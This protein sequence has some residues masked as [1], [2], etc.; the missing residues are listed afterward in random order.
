M[1]KKELHDLLVE[2]VYRSEN[3]ARTLERIVIKNG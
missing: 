3:V 2:A 1:K